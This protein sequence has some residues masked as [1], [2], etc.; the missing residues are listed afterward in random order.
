MRFTADPKYKKLTFLNDY[1]R[2][3]LAIL[4]K[5]NKILK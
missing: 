2:L 3:D 1:V 4:H 5:R